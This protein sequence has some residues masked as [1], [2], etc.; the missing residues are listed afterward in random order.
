[1]KLNSLGVID[2][3]GFIE[4]EE[5][6]LAKI[7]ADK[8][9][10]P[11][12]QIDE[13]LLKN[14]YRIVDYDKD[15]Y[16]LT[17]NKKLDEELIITKFNAALK[18]F[19]TTGSYEI[20]KGLGICKIVK[21]IPVTVG[22]FFGAAIKHAEG[23]PTNPRLVANNEQFLVRAALQWYKNFIDPDLLHITKIEFLMNSETARRE[24][25]FKGPSVKMYRYDDFVSKLSPYGKVKFDKLVTSFLEG[26]F[27]K[28]NYP[29]LIRPRIDETHG[30]K[31]T[32][33]PFYSRTLHALIVTLAYRTV[34]GLIDPHNPP[35]WF[36]PV[37]DF[38]EDMVLGKV[39]VKS[40]NNY[41]KV[42]PLTVISVSYLWAEGSHTKDRTGIEGFSSSDCSVIH[43]VF[44]FLRTTYHRKLCET[45]TSIQPLHSPEEYVEYILKSSKR[46]LPKVKV[47]LDRFKLALTT[48]EL[49]Y[50]DFMTF[51]RT[52]NDF[53]QLSDNE[54]EAKIIS[55]A[56]S[57]H[58][59]KY[60]KEYINSKINW[61]KRKRLAWSRLLSRK[62]K[63]RLRLFQKWFHYIKLC[64]QIKSRFDTDE[65]LK[66]AI[67]S[68]NENI[69][70]MWIDKL[71]AFG[72]NPS[73]LS[74]L[75]TYQH[76]IEMVNGPY[77]T[78]V[79]RGM[80]VLQIRFKS[81]IHKSLY[82]LFNKLLFQVIT[83]EF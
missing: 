10:R 49:T 44:N 66:I 1:M 64:E 81:W 29:V 26:F 43:Q 28:K 78:G 58:F 68:G 71:C 50:R 83:K 57:K 54:I 19:R 17:L 47:N 5:N 45:I 61:D 52:K 34:T 80:G 33:E 21:I 65:K 36:T 67:I 55:I 56:Q 12:K 74:N 31:L 41:I 23:G 22:F 60:L 39:F 30:K 13:N 37:E 75:F 51:L 69:T 35:T 79:H 40:L 9:H 24:F 77:D 15:S 3:K 8:F 48:T 72:E 20:M 38:H 2:V 62:P 82:E 6:I 53:R 27:S 42:T 14:I 11:D 25:G 76:A 16:L 70:Q 63:T 73:E 46:T 4:K 32:C 7:C 59:F 18:K